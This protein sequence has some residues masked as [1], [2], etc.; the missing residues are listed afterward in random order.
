MFYF[1][2]PLD[3]STSREFSEYSSS[4]VKLM[5][6]S[7]LFTISKSTAKLVSLQFQIIKQSSRY[8]F[9]LLL[10][11]S[12]VIHLLFKVWGWHKLAPCKFPYPFLYVAKYVCSWKRMCSFFFFRTNLLASRINSLLKRLLMISEYLFIQY[13]RAFR[14]R[15][16]VMFVYKYVTSIVTSFVLWLTFMVNI[17][18]NQD[19][20]EHNFFTSEH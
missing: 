10:L 9:S 7:R 12:F 11:F 3:M 14:L 17:S 5:L 13:S 16:V 20:F 19:H 18:W 2:P 4:S 6:G 8:L 1:S 15:S